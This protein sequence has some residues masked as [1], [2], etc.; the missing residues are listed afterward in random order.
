MDDPHPLCHRACCKASF[1]GPTHQFGTDCS[2]DACSGARSESDG[3]ATFENLGQ[4]LGGREIY[5]VCHGTS[6]IG[7]CHST[8]HTKLDPR[9]ASARPSTWARTV[10]ASSPTR[11]CIRPPPPRHRCG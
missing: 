5:P 11:S 10:G 7:R 1:A 2:M 9:P 8:S 4:E 6:V 3:T